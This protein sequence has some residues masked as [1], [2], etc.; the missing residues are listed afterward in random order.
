MSHSQLADRPAGSDGQPAPNAP[1][2]GRAAIRRARTRRAQ[3]TSLLARYVGYVGYFVGAGLISGAVVHHPLDPARYTRIAACGVLV[4]LAA[5]VLNEFFLARDKPGLSRMLLVIGASLLLSF[6]IGMLSGG[7]QHFEDFPARGAVLVPLG[8]TVSFIAYAAKDAQTSWR[9]I[10]SPVGL[11]VLLTALI[12]FAGLRYVAAGMDEP[13]EGG[14][15]SH[16]SAEQEEA[17]QE[18]RHEP[19]PAAPASQ[20]GTPPR[21]SGAV[22]GSGHGEGHAH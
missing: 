6:G 9:R 18:Q 11:A 3:K 10:F 19:A 7:L 22:K 20:P 17:G 13:A 12:S 5:T 15:H 2:P 8:I 21:G 4:F 1:G 16:G 14:G